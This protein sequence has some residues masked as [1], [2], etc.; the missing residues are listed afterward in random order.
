MINGPFRTELGRPFPVVGFEPE[1][2]GNAPC[3]SHSRPNHTQNPLQVGTEIQS[4]FFAAP[5]QHFNHRF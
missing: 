3:H 1:R 4:G 2:L 5:V